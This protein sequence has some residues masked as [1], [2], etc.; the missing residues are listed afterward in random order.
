MNRLS[1]TIL[2]LSPLLSPAWGACYWPDGTLNTDSAI[3]KCPNSNTCCAL[4]R[5]IEPGGDIT[6]GGA[7]RDECLPNGLC[8]NRG[9]NSTDKTSFLNYFRDFCSEKD[10]SGCWKGLCAG[11]NEAEGIGQM[12]PCSGTNSSSTW[13][14]GDSQNCC[15]GAGAIT[16]NA[17]GAVANSSSASAHATATSTSVQGSSS[18]A[19][20][21]SGAT[22]SAA[23][24]GSGGLST[25]AK[26]G[27][28]VGVS[29][30]GIALVAGIS[31][32]L[33]RYRRLEKRI[34]AAEAQNGGRGGA[35]MVHLY[36]GDGYSDAA[37][38]P[39]PQAE[40]AQGEG[41]HKYGHRHELPEYVD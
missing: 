41:P 8:Q 23:P 5:A 14:C 1:I 33:V 39:T 31:I 19:S 27:I 17:N 38:P 12:T 25:S 9:H 21:T 36:P 26:A 13:C 34:A 6:K 3:Q 37:R 16:L 24:G 7:V 29:L 20:A 28:G 15:G 2:L 10:W 30:T 32:L 11:G 4:N 40:M 35:E 22:S 18:V